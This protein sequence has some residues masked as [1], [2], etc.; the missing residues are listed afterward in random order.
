[1]SDHAV[2]LADTVLGVHWRS[3]EAIRKRHPRP[4][5]TVR[6][7]PPRG[8]RK[9]RPIDGALIDAADRW[10]LE[11]GGW[12]VVT[13]YLV[14]HVSG[15]PYPWPK[16]FLHRLLMNPP[17]GMQ[18]DHIN[19]NRLDNRRCNLRLCT[20]TQNGQNKGLSRANTSG[21]RGVRFENGKWVARIRV[22]WVLR[23]LGG[24]STPEEAS[25]AYQRAARDAWGEF[26][27]P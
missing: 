1:V 6:A 20:T 17:P 8:W 22:N 14:R 15:G 12:R 23:Q 10:L 26:A 3:K 5:V 9:K 7:M 4:R 13:G 21:I 25:E 2:Q 27:R 16:E 18:V 11:E 19:G 24:Y